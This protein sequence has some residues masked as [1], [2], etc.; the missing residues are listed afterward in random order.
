MVQSAMFF[1]R[2]RNEDGSYD[3]ICPACFVT[4]AA[5]SNEEQLRSYELGHIC[6]PVR[7]AEVD[8]SRGRARLAPLG[9]AGIDT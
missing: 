6:D 7:L 1:P 4:V 8:E 5:A 9:Q 2:R 3:S